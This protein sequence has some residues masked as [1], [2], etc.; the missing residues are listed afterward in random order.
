MFGFVKALF[1]ERDAEPPRAV[2][3]DAQPVHVLRDGVVGLLD[4]HLVFRAPGEPAVTA[5]L[6]D[7]AELSL[8]GTASVTTPC[9]AEL[10]RRGIPVVW[11][12]ASGHYLGQSADLSGLSTAT[13][14]A[15]YAAAADPGRSLAIAKALIG[16]KIGSQRGLLRR[17][18]GAAAP[19][20]RRLD[21]LRA[22][23]VPARGR[24]ALLGLEGSAA[25]IFYE[26]LPE[27]I[28]PSRRVGFAWRGRQR[29][30]PRDP[31]NALLSYCYAVVAGEC[32]VAALSAGLDPACGFYHGE[33]PGRPALALDLMEP[34]RPLVADHAALAA[35]NRGELRPEHFTEEKGAVR[36]T[37]AGRRTLLAALED[38]WSA[39]LPG[40]AALTWRAATGRLARGLAAH[41]RDGAP[42]VPIELA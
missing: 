26:A 12:S 28:A 32:A 36:L 38:R 30:P 31:L 41:L 34:F 2:V 37:E 22:A 11:R 16:A 40:R 24:E 25:A 4:R 42:F 18:L 15:Q 9:L 35:I 27:I 14:R 3:P 39:T 21:R 33:R 13:R 29:R 5:R 20:V 7:V 1:A 6:D 10:M 23:V 19:S 8:F 17:A